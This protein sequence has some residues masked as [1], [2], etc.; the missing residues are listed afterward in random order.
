M[1]FPGPR[2]AEEKAQQTVELLKPL[3]STVM[4]KPLGSPIASSAASPLDAASRMGGTL[5]PPAIG[6]VFLPVAFF[7]WEGSP[8]KIDET[9]KNEEP[10]ANLSTGGPRGGLDWWEQ[11]LDVSP[12]K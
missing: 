3:K 2:F 10:Y 6:A 9:E 7:G 1:N 12:W 5:G 4:P 11:E 8:T